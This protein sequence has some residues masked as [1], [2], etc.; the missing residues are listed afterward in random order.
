VVIKTCLFS[1]ALFCCL[2]AT[3]QADEVAAEVSAIS[4]SP[5]LTGSVE[6]TGLSPNARQLAQSLHIATD[7]EQLHGLV[8]ESVGLAGQVALS[9]M[10][11]RTTR[12]ILAA[13]LE[14]NDA[15]A[16][17]S[18]EMLAISEHQ[19]ALQ[20]K[21]G[22]HG[23]LASTVA[24]VGSRA[25]GLAGGMSSPMAMSGVVAGMVMTGV[26]SVSA[27][28]AKRAGPA[29]PANTEISP[30]MVAPLFA[31]GGS[32]P[33]RYATFILAYLSAQP[34]G[35]KESKRDALLQSWKATPG[36]DQKPLS[37]EEWSKI[38]GLN[39]SLDS[40]S[41]VQL[42][43]RESMLAELRDALTPININLRELSEAF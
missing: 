13:Y 11:S 21:K 25:A 28:G 34:E 16:K 7:I 35:S 4:T 38:L 33:E 37:K 29:K 1:A 20:M 27:Y 42:A 40:L 14:L 3:A 18:D 5:P 43:K 32:R 9:R 19:T 12:R 31:Y 22:V 39:A 15:L 26:A 2:A 10:E 41:S 24:S 8:P 30:S 17:I 36:K 6:A 23:Q